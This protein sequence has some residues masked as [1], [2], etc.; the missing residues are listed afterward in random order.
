[1][2]NKSVATLILNRNLPAVS[3]K[4][5]E[6]LRRY[7]DGM[8]DY[9][10]IESGSDADKL[11]RYCSFWANWPEALA[12]G[13]HYPRGF[14]YGLQ[15]VDR[16]GKRYDYYFFVTGDSQFPEAPT[17]KILVEIMKQY[18]KI[19]ILSPLS[20]DWGEVKYFN[21]GSD[22][23]CVWLIP[24]V[25]W[26]MRRDLLDAIVAKDNP[27]YMNYFYDG[28]NFRGYDADTEIII[29]GYQHDYATAVTSRAKFREDLDLTDKN[30]DVMKT[31][32]KLLHQ[33]LMYEEGL[34]WMR[35]KY[36]FRS[37]LEMRDWAVREYKDFL[38]RN[39]KYE[40]LSIRVRAR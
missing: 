25:G 15:E 20:T 29:R 1:M 39:P 14:N 36:G 13:L 27:S 38:Q 24:H 19:G 40:E 11:S 32:R 10:V 30:A 8:A 22:V 26:L 35:K 21:D 18:P 34:A 31:E 17:I 28:T 4:L 12:K 3:D 5:V 9:Y 2:A 37:K 23:K 33:R 6:H 16:T 7:N